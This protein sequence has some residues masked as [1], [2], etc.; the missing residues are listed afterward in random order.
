MKENSR[1]NLNINKK[2]VSIPFGAKIEG[3]YFPPPSKSFA[4]RC[5]I[6]ASFC[7]KESLIRNLGNSEDVKATLKIIEKWCKTEKKYGQVLVKPSMNGRPPDGR[8]FAKGSATLARFLMAIFSFLEGER[9]IDG[10]ENLRK[11]DFSSSISVAKSLGAQIYELGEKGK[12]PIKI[13]GKKPQNKEIEI[14][15]PLS[16]QFASGV[17]IALS[18]LKKKFVVKVKNDVSF[19]YVKMTEKVMK[20]FG[21]KITSSEKKF[22][23]EKSD[24]QGIDIEV[25]KDYSNASFFIAGAVASGGKIRIYG[26][27]KNSFQGDIKILKILKSL[28]VNIKWNDNFLEVW[29]APA[30]GMNVDIKETPDLLPPL[31]VI[32]LKC[33]KDSI[34]SGVSRLKEKESS[35]SEI[36]AKAINKIGGK[37]KIS[38]DILKIAPSISY[39]GATLDPKN[40]HRIA[41]TFAMFGVLAKGTKVRN[42]DCVK[43]SYPNFW[44]DFDKILKT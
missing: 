26:L 2:S 36:L 40:D 23:I 35:R 11:R 19:P 21:A 25:E 44:K 10:D 3:D 33:P 16:S 18:L 6:I 4:I 27:D 28:E 12:L 7:K 9:V 22:V 5:L 15:D 13:K 20:L 32:A 14:C 41:M 42:C 30:N 39:K 17:L 34:F 43:K 1:R 8:S 29:G 31:S 38:E 37:S 24:F